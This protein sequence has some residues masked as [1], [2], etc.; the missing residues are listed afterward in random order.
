MRGQVI[1][2]ALQ[3]RGSPQ[4]VLTQLPYLGGV[5]HGL[6]RQQWFGCDP[7]RVRWAVL[8]PAAQPGARA[9]W[10]DENGCLHFG[11]L[12]HGD[13]DW[14]AQRAAA[15]LQGIRTISL[16]IHRH[17]VDAV[18]TQVQPWL[19]Y[20]P[21]SPKQGQA[22]LPTTIANT[23]VSSP[24]LASLLTFSLHWCTPL[25]MASRARVAAG[26]GGLPPTP[27]AVLRSL[28]RRATELEPEWTYAWGMNPKAQ[29]AHCLA[30]VADL[31]NIRAAQTA[32]GTTAHQMLPFA[33]PYGSRTKAR[34]FERHGL[35]GRQTF[36]LPLSTA[37]R[38][39]LHLGMWLG[40]GEGGSFGCGRY[41]LHPG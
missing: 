11:V 15:A 19:A 38:A 33:W 13:A 24:A 20:W 36:C 1:A 29:T 17:A 32:A 10:L 3:V 9:Q 30:W 8:A 27:L 18:H 5:L 31:E 12:W 40:V 39:M 4:G 35:L 21:P 41:T 22:T 23:T 2:V 26:A 37:T 34:P 28:H 7:A 14:P 16:G 6:L 25:H